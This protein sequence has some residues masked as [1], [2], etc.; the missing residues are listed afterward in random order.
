MKTHPVYDHLIIHEDGKVFSQKTNKFLKFQI[1]KKG[2]ATLCTRLNGRNSKAILLRHHRLV[3]ETYIENP[4]NKPFINH[5]DG[6]KLNNTVSNLEWV[7]SKENMIHAAENNLL[8]PQKGVDNTNSKL[9]EKDVLYIRKHYKPRH[10]IFGARALAEKY[11]VHHST[12]LDAYNNKT[13]TNI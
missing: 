8:N 13:Y 2:Y 6:N 12:I 1:N 7:S 3:A 11:N 9:T 10:R 4:D 5:I